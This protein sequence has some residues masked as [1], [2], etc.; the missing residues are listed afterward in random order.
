[1]SLQVELTGSSVFDYVHPGDH[2]E[3]AEQLGMKLPP[4]RGTLSQGT[5]EDGGSSASSSSHAETP[6]PGRDCSVSLCVCDC[7]G[8]WPV[9]LDSVC[10]CVCVRGLEEDPLCRS[11]LPLSSSGGAVRDRR[12]GRPESSLEFSSG[13]YRL[14]LPNVPIFIVLY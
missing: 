11:A 2:V 13:C 6:E 12:T 9:V 4:G 10:V 7:V 3:M 8:A 1:M 5:G 14:C